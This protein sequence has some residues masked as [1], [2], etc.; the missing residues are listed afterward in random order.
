MPAVN[1]SLLQD[2]ENLN[3]PRGLLNRN[4]PLGTFSR[5]ITLAILLLDSFGPKAMMQGTVRGRDFALR[6]NL[7]WVLNGY[8]R[9]RRVLVRWLQRTESTLTPDEEQVSLLLLASTRRLCGPQSSVAVLLP[10]M[11]L[12]FSWAQCLSELICPSINRQSPTLQIELSH[13]V[14]EV[15]QWSEQSKSSVQPLREIFLPILKELDDRNL[16]LQSMDLRLWVII[17]LLSVGLIMTRA[18]KIQESLQSLLGELRHITSPATC[19]PKALTEALDTNLYSANQRPNKT[20]REQDINEE[21]RAPK[22][23]CLPAAYP[24]QNLLQALMKSLSSLLDCECSENLTN[25]RIA[26]Q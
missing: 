26:I 21:R 14:N 25:L 12:N 18:N 19:P 5:A 4:I 23:V 13:V 8:N 20:A 22:R 7:P 24:D 11:G 16:N 6:Q 17:H 3:L 15:V 2:L 9:L 1:G 10:D